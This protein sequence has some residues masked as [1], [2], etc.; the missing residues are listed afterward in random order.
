MNRMKLVGLVVVAV[1]VLGLGAYATAA[2]TP[3]SVTGKSTCGG[4]SG[5]V[6]GCCVM[7]TDKDGVRWI[8]RGDSPSLKAAFAARHDDKTMTATLTGAPA[9]KKGKDGKDYKEVKVSDVKIA[10]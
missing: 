6:T 3:T 2:D 8:L 5:V 1:L 10:S 4:C 9:T 7:L